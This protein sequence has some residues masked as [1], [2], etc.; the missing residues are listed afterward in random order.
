MKSISRNADNG[1]TFESSIEAFFSQFQIFS[2]ARKAH[3]TKTKGV[4]FK[5]LWTFLVSV[6]LSGRSSYRNFQMQELPFSE[7]T[8]RNLLNNPKID[9]QVFLAC[10]AQKVTA[11][12]STFT[13]EERKNVFIVDD[14]M[15]ERLNVKKV[16]L[17]ALQYDHASHT[18]KKGFRFL[19][20]GWS[21]GN[22]YVPVL[23]SLLSGK[24]KVAQENETDNRSL[25]S[26][27]K[28][29][30]Q[31]KGTEVLLELLKL[32]LK[33]GVK[34]PYVLF[35]SWFSSPTMFKKIREL[36]LHVVT[37]LKRSSKVY[38]FYQG[39]AI[40]VKTLFKQLKKRR[41]RSRYL[42]SIEV[43]AHV[44]DESIPIKLVYVR[45]RNKRNEYLVLATTDMTLS[46]DEII[47]LYGKRWAIEVFFKM[48]KQYLQLAKYQGLSYDGIFAHTTLVCVS[49]TILSVQ[50]RQEGDDRTIGELFYL[51]VSELADLTFEEAI[52]QLLEMFKE[53]LYEE[54]V[55]S[56]SIL[57]EIL[58]K[59]L[60]L[61]PKATQH[62]LKR[63][64]VY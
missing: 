33:R 39:K 13:S 51:M 49:Y 5:V 63:A 2:I 25:A 28:Q 26:K 59:F 31:G 62:K 58:E 36:E 27:R 46:E 53:A 44:G 6:L 7:K 23:F 20:L 14:S 1:N 48:C 30:A 3:A 12:F 16:E 61:L 60:S 22:S 15:Y 55:L 38:Y 56:A 43:E 45:N 10:L 11:Y 35:D 37:L 54:M 8:Y 64:T 9:W 34:A 40:D 52:F 32:A 17:A 41:G 21:D 24:N 18:Y 57:E 29:Q 50:H 47:Q 4:S 19:Q 42:L